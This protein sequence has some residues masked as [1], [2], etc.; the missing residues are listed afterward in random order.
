MNILKRISLVLIVLLSGFIFSCKNKENVDDKIETL[1]IYT[2]NDF[3]GSLE[4]EDG[5][6]GA[7]RMA[8]YIKDGLAE[9]GDAA[10]VVSAGDMFQGS[11]LSNY[12]YGRTVIDVMNYTSFS[13]MTIGNH[14]FDWKLETVLNYRDGNIENGEANFPFLGCN[15]INKNTGSIPEG[16]EPYTI[17]E[18]KNLKIGI[19]GYIGAGQEED[20]L[21]ENVADYYFDQPID[22]I[23]NYSYY[24]RTVENCNVIITVGHDA[25]SSVDK[26]ISNLNGDYRVDGIINGHSHATYSDTYRR[27]DGVVIPCCQAGSAGTH[28]G[29]LKLTIDPETNSVTGG[30]C[31]VKQM[32][33]RVSKDNNIEEMIEK[34]KEETAPIFQRVLC[35]AGQKIDRIHAADWVADALEDYTDA[36]VAFVNYGG[37]RANAFPIE[38]GSDVTYSK[39]YQISPFDNLVVTFKLSGQ[40]IINMLNVSGIN[41]SYSISGDGLNGYFINGVKI[42][43]EATYKVAT[44]DFLFTNNSYNFHYGTDAVKTNIVLR[45]VIVETLENLSKNGKTWVMNERN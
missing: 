4:E 24:L 16:I 10:L 18:R 12:N 38:K 43:P 17:V 20:I 1:T 2:V 27:S 41:H 19:I 21:A 7:A 28:V 25:S 15:I 6:K 33:Y 8:S 34:L 11:A 26:Q 29:V 22:C 13:S 42:D 45:D 31:F 40:L 5:A 9:F 14:E 30:S 23:K 37:I 36:D 3:H 44:I 32:S 35:Q 39:V